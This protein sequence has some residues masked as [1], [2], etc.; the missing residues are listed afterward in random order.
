MKKL[1]YIIL[2]FTFYSFSF[3]QNDMDYRLRAGI[4]IGG[5]A[6]LNIPQEI[7]KLEGYQPSLIPS[8]EFNAHYPLDKNWGIISGLRL[9]Y[10]GM[11]TTANV[12]QWYVTMNVS[13]GDNPGEVKGY[14]T[15][16]VELNSVNGYITI[17]LLLSYD[18]GTHWRFGAG[19]FG[20]VAIDRNF[21]GEASD[22]DL[23]DLMSHQ[24]VESASFDFSNEVRHFDFG[25]QLSADWRITEKIAVS[26]QFAFSLTPLFNKDFHNVAYNLYNIY[27]NIGA[28]YVF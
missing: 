10:K 12:K 2:F 23:Y 14:F 16:T 20:A 21:T 3:S 13:R 5:T 1:F 17:P 22:G 26:A 9:E 24:Y 7:R 15:G 6:P 28:A 4:S 27:G 25:A 18:L 8:I 11:H 19:G